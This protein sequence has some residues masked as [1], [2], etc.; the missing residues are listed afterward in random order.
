VIRGVVQFVGKEND[1][2]AMQ[3][4]HCLMRLQFFFGES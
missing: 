1:F 3:C 4:F 2:N